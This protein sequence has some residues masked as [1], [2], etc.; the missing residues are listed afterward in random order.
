VNTLV[1]ALMTMKNFACNRIR[2]T[3]CISERG[4]GAFSVP[5]FE[6]AESEE[7]RQNINVCAKRYLIP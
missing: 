4:E 3:S 6:V 2:H 5:K 7:V 1:V